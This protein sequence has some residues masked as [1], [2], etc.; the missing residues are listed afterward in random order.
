VN[1]YQK[2][3]R[4]KKRTSRTPKTPRSIFLVIYVE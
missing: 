3:T 4:E 1:P 2:W